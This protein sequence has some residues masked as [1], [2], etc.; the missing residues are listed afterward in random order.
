MKASVNKH[1]KVQISDNG[2]CMYI[3]VLGDGWDSHQRSVQ[4]FLRTGGVH[5]KIWAASS[6]YV[7][8]KNSLKDFKDLK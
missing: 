1:E 2:I 6:L 7:Q 5:Y 8:C 4:V 3:Y